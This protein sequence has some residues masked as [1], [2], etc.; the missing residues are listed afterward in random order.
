MAL[1]LPVTVILP[2]IKSGL[3]VS[4]ERSSFLFHGEGEGGYVFHF[5]IDLSTTA[6][7]LRVCT[8]FG[9]VGACLLLGHRQR[10]IFVGQQAKVLSDE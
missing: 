1:P 10:F 9:D 7:A 5:S 6:H 8:G 3:T 4:A 2:S